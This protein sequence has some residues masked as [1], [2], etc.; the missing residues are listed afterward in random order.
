[1]RYGRK[2]VLHCLSGYKPELDEMVEQ[3]LRDGVVFV[4][5]VGKDCSRV[6][7]IIDELVV[8]DGSDETRFIL[9]SFHE[10]ESL[11]EA[12]DFAR[13]LSGEYAGEI[14]VVHL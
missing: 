13:S 7:D 9:T 1:M 4:G 11:D 2:I 3:F 5:V 8:G 14:Q 6:D 12:I 10:G